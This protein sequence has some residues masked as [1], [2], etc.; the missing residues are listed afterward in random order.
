MKT[1]VYL[2]PCGI[3]DDSEHSGN[4]FVRGDEGHE[5]ADSDLLRL[6]ADPGAEWNVIDETEAERDARLAALLPQPQESTVI[7][8]GPEP[9]PP[10]VVSD[11]DA[12]PDSATADPPADT[13]RVESRVGRFAEPQRPEPPQDE[14]V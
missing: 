12:A 6:S 2:G 5:V 8:P 7:I 10:I 11:D 9:D 14:E 4:V 13:P 3:F 1:L